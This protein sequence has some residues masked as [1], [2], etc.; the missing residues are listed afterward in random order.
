MNFMDKLMH[1]GHLGSLPARAAAPAARAAR[2]IPAAPADSAGRRA[3]CIGALAGLGLLGLGRELH[4]QTVAADTSR[5]EPPRVEGPRIEPLRSGE[6]ARFVFKDPGYFADKP[7]TVHY[8]KA[9]SA[10]PDARVLLAIHGMERNAAQARD[11]W[12]PHAERHGLIVLAPEFDAA[13]FPSRLFN[14]G[15]IE[16]PDR[17][18]W[19]FGLIERLFDAVRAGEQLQASDYLLFGHSAGAQFVHRLMLLADEPRVSLAVAANA[20]SYTI[21]AYPSAGEDGFPYALDER[22]LPP[23][24]LRS[25]FARKLVVMLGEADTATDAANLPRARQARAQG[26]NRLER[27]R[28]FF[29]RSAQQARQ[30]GLALA[31][32]LVTVPG[33]GHNARDMSKAAAA[34][35]LPAR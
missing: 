1:R 12:R 5:A 30:S 35:L 29:D 25:V 10:G 2:A 34:V 14:M 33:V 21:A 7:V 13:R 9:R 11:N 19:T 4:A 20:G 18:R 24:Q 17:T 6:A 15:N 28:H 8:Y 26:A 16:E 31:W 32:Q 23:R 3:V 22:I 27:G